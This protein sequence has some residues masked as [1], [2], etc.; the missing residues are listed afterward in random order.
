MAFFIV[1]GKLRSGK[2]LLATARMRDRLLDG[3]RVATNF[4]LY[5]EHML[6]V[7][8]RKV[9]CTRLPDLPSVEDFEALGKGST[10]DYDEAS[11]GLIVIDEGSGN[12]NSRDWAD[13]SRQQVIDWLKHS[14][15]LRWDVY[16]IVQSEN[17]LDKQ[18]REAFGEHL[19]ICKRSDRM[20]IPLI[21]AFFKILGIELR[22]PKIHIG[23]VRYGLRPTDPVVDRW[24][25]RARNLYRAYNTEQK[26]SR[27]NSPGLCSYLPPY[28]IKGRYMNKFQIARAIAGTY[29]LGALLLGVCL[30]YSFAWW[31]FKA[32]QNSVLKN[33]LQTAKAFAPKSPDQ[34]VAIDGVITGSDGRVSVVYL[35]D[36]RA[37]TSPEYQWVREGLQ[38]KVGDVWVLKRGM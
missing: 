35:S 26:F 30:T 7:D 21:G 12:F 23:I 8:A 3:R 34:T 1:T 9:D 37:L 5:L 27:E 18:I 4:D 16:I 19:V 11:F 28:H 29:V 2:S 38:V 20:S 24:M 31:Q 25:Y 33:G 15:K 36:G 14:G 17:M 13:K 10:G 6:P 32:S 22:P